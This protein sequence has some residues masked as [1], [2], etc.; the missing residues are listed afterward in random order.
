MTYYELT[1]QIAVQNAFR[2]FRGKL[3]VNIV[4][5]IF[6]SSPPTSQICPTCESRYISR[7]LD[8]QDDTLDVESNYVL[9]VQ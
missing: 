5:L 1:L 9:C 2:K 6:H 7:Q 8:D 3:P 4:Y